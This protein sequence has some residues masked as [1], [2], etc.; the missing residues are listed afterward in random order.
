MPLRPA[1]ISSFCSKKR[2]RACRR[3][4]VPSGMLVHY[5]S[6]KVASIIDLGAKS[7][8]ESRVL[9]LRTQRGCT[10]RGLIF[11]LQVPSAMHYP[12]SHNVLS[13][14]WTS[15]SI[16]GNRL[17]TRMHYK[18]T[19]SHSFFTTLVISPSNTST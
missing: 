4:I 16:S 14:F 5:R 2:L 7:R 15:V 17:S 6:P 10:S 18:P 19:D 9:C 8:H 3:S 13:L 11:D 12:L 1:L